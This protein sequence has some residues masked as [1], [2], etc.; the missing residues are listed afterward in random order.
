MIMTIHILLQLQTPNDSMFL[1]D[2]LKALGELGSESDARDQGISTLLLSHG[3]NIQS[4]RP[5]EYG[6]SLVPCEGISSVWKMGSGI[7]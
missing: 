4:A 1:H 2:F 5:Q 7:C 3:F 6:W